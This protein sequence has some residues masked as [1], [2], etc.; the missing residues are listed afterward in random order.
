MQSEGTH[1][2]HPVQLPDRFRASILLRALSK[3]L[4]STQQPRGAEG[5]AEKPDLCLSARTGMNT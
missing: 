5:L 3:S 2:D 1:K 4:Q